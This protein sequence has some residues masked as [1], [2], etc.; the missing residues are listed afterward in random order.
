M[1]KDGINYS[2][3]FSPNFMVRY[4]PGH[5]RDLSKNDIN[6]KYANLYALN[7]T[8]AIEDGLSAIL[9]FDFKMNEKVNN[10]SDKEK[11][12]ISMGQ[13]F[14]PEKNKDIPSASSL[15]QKMSD[16]VGEI[17]Y[18]FSKIGKID[19]KFSIDHNINDLNYNEI[20]SNFNFGKVNFNL[21]YLEEQNH[22]GDEHYVNAGISLNLNDNNKLSVESKKNFKTDSTELYNV[23]YQYINDCLTAG[24]VFRR[25]YY[26]DNDIEQKDSLIF[27]IT[28]T[29]FG[30]VKTPSVINP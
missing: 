14:S 9:G 21:D 12:S 27:Q 7:K 29:P 15:D 26:E 23:S 8:S 11:L 6:L 19:Y 4:A 28:F 3:L 13:V 30:G 25:E 17:N 10:G 2:N 16:I 22:V 1:K 5:M 20:S 18:N 24:L